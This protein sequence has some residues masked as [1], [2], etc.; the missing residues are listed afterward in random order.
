M[1]EMKRKVLPLEL[2]R[3]QMKQLIYVDGMGTDKGVDAVLTEVEHNHEAAIFSLN[4]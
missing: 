3:L 1:Y 4:I 2:I